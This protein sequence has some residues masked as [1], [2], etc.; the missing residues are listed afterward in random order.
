M[1]LAFRSNAHLKSPK[2]PFLQSPLVPAT[3]RNPCPLSSPP[4]RGALGRRRLSLDRGGGVIHRL[5][6]RSVAPVHRCLVPR[7]FRRADF[8]PVEPKGLAFG[9]IDI[10]DHAA[11]RGIV[12]G[13]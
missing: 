8:G 4:S 13:D 5:A 7:R 9:N 10:G 12:I 2:T 6:A 1:P 11:A 3:R